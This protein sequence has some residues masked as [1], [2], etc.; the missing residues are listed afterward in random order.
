MVNEQQNDWDLATSGKHFVSQLQVCT[1][2][3]VGDNYMYTFIS[4]MLLVVFYRTSVQSS[5]GLTPFFLMHF[6]EAKLPI[7]IKMERATG[8][9]GS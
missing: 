6:R 7:H 1:K 9:L 8:E 4:Y 3:L 2:V 5:T